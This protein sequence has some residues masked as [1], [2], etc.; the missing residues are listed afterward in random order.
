MLP[1]PAPSSRPQRTASPVLPGL[2]F[3][4]YENIG[5]PAIISWLALT[6]GATAVDISM[7][8]DTPESPGR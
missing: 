5:N 8:I 4:H 3:P 6:H 2:T 7:R 1:S